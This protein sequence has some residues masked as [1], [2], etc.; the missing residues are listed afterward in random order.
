VRHEQF[1]CDSPPRLEVEIRSG[2][3]K[4]IKGPEGTVEVT[5]DGPHPEQF[6]VTHTGSAIVV[7]QEPSGSWLI[8]SN[9]GAHRVT[10]VAPEAARLEASLASAD[11]AVELLL[12]S[13]QADTASGDVRAGVVS[14]DAAVKSASGD[15]RVEAVGGELRF[16]SASGELR[17]GRL[18]SGWLRTASGDVVVDQADGTIEVKTA[19][20]NVRVS[21]F[22][23]AGLSVK[24]V[25]GDFTVGIPPGTEL[26]FEADTMSGRVV[27][28][29]PAPAEQPAER[30]ARLSFRSV[31]GDL[32][33][34]RL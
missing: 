13:L 7:R 24:T 20:G 8:G 15:V 33:I 3:V 31:S 4:V 18:G 9:R 25:S 6:E 26:G 22:I 1:I 21:R 19:S 11:L 34:R 32:R 27:L 2:D 16:S 17:V 29:D 10:I 30:S 14:G 12:A 5:I 28:P 23:G